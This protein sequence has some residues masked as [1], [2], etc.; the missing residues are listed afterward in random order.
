MEDRKE[1]DGLDLERLEGAKRAPSVEVTRET[2]EF[3][4][5]P[6]P[7]PAPA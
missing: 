4:S 7:A 1:D 3:P 6:A 5:C 2:S